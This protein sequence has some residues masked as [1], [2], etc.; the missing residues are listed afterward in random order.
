MKSNR[1]ELALIARGINSDLAKQLRK[2]GLYLKTLRLMDTQELKSYGLSPDDITSIH[3]GARP[4][5]PIPDLIKVLFANRW[6]CCVCRDSSQPIVVHHIRPWAESRDHSP[7]N[8]AVLCS[9]HHSEA[10]TKR[11]LDMALSADRLIGLKAAWED[12]VKRLDRLDVHTATQSQGCHW[13][14][15]NH[16]RLYELAQEGGVT[17]T[18]LAG[19]PETFDAGSCTKDGMAVRKGSEGLLHSGASAQ[20]L[21]LYMT[22]MLRAVMHGS[23]IRNISDELDRGKLSAWIVEGDLVLVQ[24]R[25]IF[26]NCGPATIASDPVMGKRSVNNVE[27]QFAFDRNE[28]TSVSAR[29][30]WLR[31]SQDLACL[32]KVNRLERVM[33][34]VVITGTVLAIRNAHPDIKKRA[35]E[36][37][38]YKSGLAGVIWDEDEATEDQDQDQDQDQDDFK[39]AAQP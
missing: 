5:I 39:A 15:F 31:G 25:Y 22:E 20:Y 26:N 32:I 33:Q 7:A 9:T 3:E 29:S 21:Y 10:H 35:Y 36:I 11:A 37:N 14:Y 6:L 17:F 18:R 8:L 23:V 1:T 28:G 4:P 38:L 13:W 16:L 2:Q 12:E 30:L 34:K 24:G 19:Y 27:I